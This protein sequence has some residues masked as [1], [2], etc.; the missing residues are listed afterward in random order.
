MLLLKLH[1]LIKT[2]NSENSFINVPVGYRPRSDLLKQGGSL[3]MK[4]R[5]TS[6]RHGAVLIDLDMFAGIEDGLDRP[7]LPEPPVVLATTTSDSDARYK[8]RQMAQRLTS[9]RPTEQ[10]R[11]LEKTVKEH[12]Q[13]H[14]EKLEEVRESKLHWKLSSACMGGVRA[15]LARKK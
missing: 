10:Q 7:C 3:Q 12:F 14:E 2:S 11:W 15:A 1:D 4:V 8:T 6:A 9:V 13:D 5:L